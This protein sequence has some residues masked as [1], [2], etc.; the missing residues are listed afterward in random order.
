[1]HT[2]QCHHYCPRPLWLA[3]PPPKWEYP[4]CASVCLCPFFLHEGGLDHAH[5]RVS[6]LLSPPSMA[7]P[8]STQM[9]ISLHTAESPHDTSPIPM[10]SP[11]HFGGIPIWV[12]EGLGIGGGDSSGDTLQCAWSSGTAVAE[13]AHLGVNLAQGKNQENDSCQV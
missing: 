5:C 13:V 11:L 10:A 4:Q 3:L 9:G 7:S 1:M 6:P 8:S 2:I 12:E